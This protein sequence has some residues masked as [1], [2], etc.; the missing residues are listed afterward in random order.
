MPT[1]VQLKYILAVSELKSFNK[2]AR[3]CNVSQPSLSTQVRKVEQE[4]EIKIFD[5][6]TKPIMPTKNGN[7]VIQQARNIL[8]ENKKLLNIRQDKGEISGD[9]HLSCI[10]SLAPYIVPLFISSFSTKYPKVNLKISELKTDEIL[11]RLLDNKIDAGLLVTPLLNKK[12]EEHKIFYEKFYV[13]TSANHVL[14]DKKNVSYKD[15]KSKSIWLLEEGHCLRNQ[16]LNLC[17][18]NKDY[19]VFKNIIF[20]SEN[21]ETLIN[22]IRNGDGFTLLPELATFGLSDYEKKKFLKKILDPAPYREVSLINSLNYAKNRII[23]ALKKEIYE[24][25]PSKVK[26]NYQNN[27]NLN[28]INI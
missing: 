20:D 15:L 25:L 9:F 10:H 2:A 19:K 28:I 3:Y 16:V 26:F 13:F 21:L 11:E 23:S 4:L 7:K 24:N 8:L 22:L 12:I 5:R 6:N 18:M 17:S 27:Q 1:L 14:Y